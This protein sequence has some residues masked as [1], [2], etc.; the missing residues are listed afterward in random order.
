MFPRNLVPL[1]LQ[2]KSSIWCQLVNVC[3]RSTYFQHIFLGQYGTYFMCCQSDEDVLLVDCVWSMYMCCLKLKYPELT[4]VTLAYQMLIKCTWRTWLIWHR[5]R[6]S[7]GHLA[8]LVLFSFYFKLHQ[9]QQYIYTNTYIYILP[10]GKISRDNIKP[11]CL[12]SVDASKVTHQ[13]NLISSGHLWCIRSF[14]AVGSFKN[15]S[16]LTPLVHSLSHSGLHNLCTQYV[17]LEM[18]VLWKLK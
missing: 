11:P 13:R 3:L 7:S 15:D 17:T 18:V 8:N 10:P 6:T 5:H 9:F 2:H 4:H 14:R 1:I 12:I 16:C